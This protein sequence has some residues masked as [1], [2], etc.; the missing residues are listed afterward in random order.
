MRAL[1]IVI[2]SLLMISCGKDPAPE[3]PGANAGQTT[4]PAID[5]E[6]LA[7]KID[8]D[9]CGLIDAARIQ[10]LLGLAAEPDT[11]SGNASKPERAYCRYAWRSGE[12]ER[13]VEVAW[14]SALADQPEKIA[15][16][17]ALAQEDLAER[18]VQEIEVPGALLSTWGEHWLTVY[19]NDRQVF[20][21]VMSETGK[22]ARDARSLAAAIAANIVH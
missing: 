17:R 5:P 4:P 13:Y 12:D 2:A 18:R 15:K 21:V 22:T 8:P 20:W 1:P 3:K 19:A 16:G 6:H 7:A 11:H 14:A 9:P 10:A